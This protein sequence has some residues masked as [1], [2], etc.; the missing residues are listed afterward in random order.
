LVQIIDDPRKVENAYDHQY[1]N[2]AR[3]IANLVLAKR[4]IFVEIGG[5][6]GQLTVPLA[7]LLPRLRFIVVDTFS[8]AYSGTLGLLNQALWS[9]ADPPGQGARSRLSRLDGGR[10]L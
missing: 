7:K 1:E 10:I 3:K 2:L 4:G 9:R 6:K 5:G 8:G